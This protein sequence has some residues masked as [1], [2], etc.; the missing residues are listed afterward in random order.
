[1]RGVSVVTTFVLPAAS[2]TGIGVPLVVATIAA[3]GA[4]VVGVARPAAVDAA[5]SDA[6]GPSAAMVAFEPPPPPEADAAS[7]RPPPTRTSAA[8]G[9][10]S[11]MRSWRRRAR[12]PCA[13]RY[14]RRVGRTI[15]GRIHRLLT[16]SKRRTT[17]GRGRSGR[18]PGVSSCRGGAVRGE[19]HQPQVEEKVDDLRGRHQ[20]A[21]AE[22]VECLV[23]P[24]RQD[25]LV[26]VHRWSSSIV[27]CLGSRSVLCSSSPGR[28][29]DV[30]LTTYWAYVSFRG[31][32]T[33]P[34][35]VSDF[36]SAP[37]PPT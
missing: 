27:Q 4:L 25:H 3:V 37:H 30:F 22:L 32:G 9:A 18:T 19:E 36:L 14:G 1:M 31:H 33:F 26:R 23:D 17:A 2:Y 15:R 12:R 29:P 34:T 28:A 21:A 6:I 5:S 7:R 35:G 11:R 13:T 24:C 8:S 20:V 10:R 16:V